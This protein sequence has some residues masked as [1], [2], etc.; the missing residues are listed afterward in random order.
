MNEKE[1]SVQELN[2]IFE[3]P[4]QE[5]I[6]KETKS[7]IFNIIISNMIA[8]SEIQ[9]LERESKKW[10]LILGLMLLFFIAIMFLFGSR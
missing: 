4:N 1:I 6:P 9:R 5:E 3:I 10:K 7:F 8:Q 2:E